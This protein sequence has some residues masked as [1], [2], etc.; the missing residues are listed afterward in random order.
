MYHDSPDPT[1]LEEIYMDEI[2]INP[3][4]SDDGIY[5]IDV[6]AGSRMYLVLNNQFPVVNYNS[7]SLTVFS[8]TDGQMTYYVTTDGANQNFIMPNTDSIYYINLGGGIS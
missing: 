8:G 5:R 7:S 6:P 2:A 1:L 3:P 4:S